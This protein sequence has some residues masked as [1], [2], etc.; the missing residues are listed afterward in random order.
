MLS[1][2]SLGGLVMSAISGAVLSVS[3]ITMKKCIGYRKY[4]TINGKK[5]W[6]EYPKVLTKDNLIIFKN[7]VISKISSLTS[8][9]A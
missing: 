9:A 3:L 2:G 5:R 8:K 7:N 4:K 1:T 6:V